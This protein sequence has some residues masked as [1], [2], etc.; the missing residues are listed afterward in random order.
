MGESRRKPPR[1]KRASASLE[2]SRDLVFADDSPVRRRFRREFDAEIES[3]I[4][5][6][7]HAHAEIEAAGNRWPQNVRTQDVRI[8]LHLALQSLFCS[9]HFLVSGYFAAAGHQLRLFAE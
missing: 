5:A 9:V 3:F 7:F 4:E 1:R 2:L 6:A 8:F